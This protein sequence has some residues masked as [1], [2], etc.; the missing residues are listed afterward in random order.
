MVAH[1]KLR[2]G[3]H[4]ALHPWEAPKAAPKCIPSAVAGLVLKL[5]PP[6]TKVRAPVR[7][8][9]AAPMVTMAPASHSTAERRFGPLRAGSHT[10]SLAANSRAQSSRSMCPPMRRHTTAILCAG[11]AVRRQCS[12]RCRAEPLGAMHVDG[13]VRCADAHRADAAVQVSCEEVHHEWLATRP[14]PS[15]GDPSL[16]AS[17]GEQADCR[18]APRPRLKSACDS[19]PITKQD[20]TA[21]L[22]H[23]RHLRHWEVWTYSAASRRAD[24]K[25]E[26]GRHDRWWPSDPA[27][28]ACRACPAVWTGASGWRL[29]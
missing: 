16:G 24:Q 20:S 22:P 8:R 18:S 27:G 19:V 14:A 23:F 11:Q 21:M 29:I 17:S 2:S 4:T 15:R 13:L 12:R 3:G 1:S 26:T 28:H 10:V 9:S 7:E 25:A 6:G 5:L